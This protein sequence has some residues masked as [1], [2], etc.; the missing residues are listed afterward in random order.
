MA[1]PFAVRLLLALLILLAVCAQAE[2]R[3]QRQAKYAK[4]I[5]EQ[6]KVEKI[7][8]KVANVTTDAACRAGYSGVGHKLC[9]STVSSVPLAR[10]RAAASCKDKHGR[11]L[12]L[13]TSRKFQMVK[14][15]LMD[16][17]PLWVGATY[18]ASPKADFFWDAGGTRVQ[19][20]VEGR[21]DDGA[22]CVV[23]TLFRSPGHLAALDCRFPR[24]FVCE[25]AD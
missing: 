15:L 22:T 17:R 5:V 12:Q 18:R 25:Q 2:P 13:E 3:A 8:E 20:K 16:D 21:A 7:V 11:L 23:L 1:G 10:Q 4:M 9:L 24:Y 6:K 19:V 14:L